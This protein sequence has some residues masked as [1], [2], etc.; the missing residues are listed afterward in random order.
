MNEYKEVHIGDGDHIIKKEKTN[1]KENKTDRDFKEGDLVFI[2]KDADDFVQGKI[3][4]IKE[5]TKK[6]LFFKYKIKRIL[7]V[8]YTTSI[9]YPLGLIPG[10]IVEIPENKLFLRKD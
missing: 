1:I 6:I 2:K 8:I 9:L 5:E 3:I 4:C 7:V 10:K